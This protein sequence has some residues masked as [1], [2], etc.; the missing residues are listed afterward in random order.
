ML[1]FILNI[2]LCSLLLIGCENEERIETLS[3]YPQRIDVDSYANEVFI[4]IE[5]SSGWEISL[6]ED[7]DWVE[8]AYYSS[9]VGGTYKMLLDISRN[10]T[11]KTRQAT[12]SIINSQVTRTISITQM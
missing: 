10:N 5:S 7:C 6:P 3:V 4:E 1:R 12:I 11:S 9:Y 8:P 2:M